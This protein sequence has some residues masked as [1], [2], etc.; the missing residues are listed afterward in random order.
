[1]YNHLQIGFFV[2]WYTSM[3]NEEDYIFLQEVLLEQE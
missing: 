3:E 1:M 2:D